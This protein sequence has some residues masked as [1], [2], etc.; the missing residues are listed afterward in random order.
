[1]ESAS[2]QKFGAF[3]FFKKNQMN[4]AD[5]KR[6]RSTNTDDY[7]VG[8]DLYDIDDSICTI[9]QKTKTSIEV[10]MRKKTDKGINCTQWFYIET[11][12]R[13]FEKVKK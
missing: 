12:E 5:V 13:Q 4:N 10:F 9:T 1:V 2:N 11:F 7:F 3:L 8:D 6:K